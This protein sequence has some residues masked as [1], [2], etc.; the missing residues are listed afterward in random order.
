MG[1]AFLASAGAEPGL[2]GVPGGGEAGFGGHVVGDLE[3]AE[4]VGVGVGPVAD[5]AGRREVGA[6]AGGAEGAGAEDGLA[7]VVGDEFA[8]GGAA[9][10]LGLARLA[11]DAVEVGG[12]GWMAAAP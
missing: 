9:A 12:E 8:V 1:L 4:E 3:V 7:D 2:Q 10:G 6:P 5:G 11:A